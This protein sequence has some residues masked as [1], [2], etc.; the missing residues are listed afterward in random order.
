M[1]KKSAIKS[2]K[3]NNYSYI[4]QS[5]SLFLLITLIFLIWNPVYLVCPLI[6]T[7]VRRHPPA[8]PSFVVLSFA[9]SLE[10]KRKNS[11]AVQLIVIGKSGNELLNQLKDVIVPFKF[12]VKFTSDRTTAKLHQGMLVLSL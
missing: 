6:F 8:S 7:D 4:K 10:Y 5:S 9:A 1:F 12:T 11:W 2:S 3:R